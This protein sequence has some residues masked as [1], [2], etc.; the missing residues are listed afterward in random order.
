MPKKDQSRINL[1]R[2]NFL[3][4]LVAAILLIVGYVIMSFN[5]IDIS[6]II[7]ILAYV[8]IIPFALLWQPKNK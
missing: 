2:M 6:P 1:G 3:L 5:E 4:L 7:L 8:V